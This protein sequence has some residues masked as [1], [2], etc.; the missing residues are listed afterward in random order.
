MQTTICKRDPIEKEDTCDLS[1]WDHLKAA[2]VEQ[3]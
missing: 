1:K 2:P 3:D